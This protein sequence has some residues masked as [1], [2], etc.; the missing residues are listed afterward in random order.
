MTE[1]TPRGR[2]SDRDRISL[3]EP[4]EVRYWT[5]ALGISEARLREVVGRVGHGAA[6]VRAELGMKDEPTEGNSGP[7]GSG[8]AADESPSPGPPPKLR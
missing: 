8:G 1:H 3:T 7:T 4:H 6:N 5:N 2:S